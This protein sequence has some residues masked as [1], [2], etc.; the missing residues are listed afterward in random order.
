MQRF[1]EVADS[2]PHGVPLSKTTRYSV[3]V[4]ATVLVALTRGALDPWLQNQAIL[5]P[6]TLAVLVAAVVG[7]LGPGL[8]AAGLSMLIS[9][10]A[11]FEPRGTLL[12]EGMSDILHL[13]VFAGVSVVV[14]LLSHRLEQA[15]GHAMRFERRL[16]RSKQRLDLAEECV[17]AGVWEWD[18]DRDSGYWSS[19]YRLLL[20]VMPDAR[21]SLAGFLDRV[22]PSDRAR[23][24][25][26][27]QRA[28]DAGEFRSRIPRA[29]PDP[30][31]D[32]A[33]QR[34]SRRA[35]RLRPPSAH[36]RHRGRHLRTEA[37]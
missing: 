2:T 11:F 33:A 15:L 9:V 21:V 32:L 30:R 7:G 25:Q 24:Q 6:F 20:G 18:V 8:V 26:D 1:A 23:V 22:H 10:V 13:T 17:D 29:A 34:G 12:V 4:I 36:H 27:L 19:G 3:A 5:L 35:R 16:E 28:L 14:C 31:R 37:C